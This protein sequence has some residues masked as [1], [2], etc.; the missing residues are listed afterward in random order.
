MGKRKFELASMIETVSDLGDTA[1]EARDIETITAEILTLKVTAGDA[2]LG[3]GQR[4]IEAKA[5]LPHGEWLP[6]LNER[7]EF[8]ERA[9]RRFMQLAREL[10]NRPAL[11]NLGATKAL[12]LLALPPEERD[13][14]VSE[15]H[16]VNGEEKTVIDM[17]SR[18]LDQAI[19][20]RD[21]ARVAAETAK[22]DA[23]SAE[24]NRA[25][26]E[27]DMAVLKKLYDA[28]QASVTSARNELSSARAELEE[29]KAKPVEV[30]VMSVDQ[31]KLDQARAEAIAEM[32]AK[33]DKA[34]AARD[35]AEEKRKKAE[36]DLADA[37][38][39][40]EEA[41]RSEKRAAITSDKD[42]AAFDL[43]F[44][45]AQEIVNKLHGL[46]LKVLGR[47]DQSADVGLRK[48]LLALSERAK[49]AAQ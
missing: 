15:S 47:E 44:G 29:L 41:S 14:F 39:R 49:E 27:T 33:L 6:W 1:P 28:A 19:R 8:S 5:L 3:I 7:V 4:L 9:A 40:L 32:Q 30:A 16:T 31:E 43:L 37:T 22:A 20:E 48:A 45:Q 25:K 17:T 34:K 10:T 42:L 12:A 13:Q 21:E 11:A 24:E 38:A 18:E 26:M 23:R 46:R 36:A 2:I 35:K